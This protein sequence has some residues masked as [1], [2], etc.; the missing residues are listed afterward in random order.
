MNRFVIFDID[1]TLADCSHRVDHA[2]AK[3]WDTFHSLADDDMVIVNVADLMVHLS[4]YAGII[5]LTGRPERY[6]YKTMEWLKR[7]GLD[8]FYEELIMREDD[9]FMKDGQ[10]KLVALETRFGDYEGVM[11]S[12]WFVVDDRDTVVEAMRNY[13]LTVLQ[14]A[15]GGY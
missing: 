9:N 5:L 4:G 2:N 1:G 11:N 13:G 12:V 8:G 6:R 10:M 14:P 15:V 3:D 7:S